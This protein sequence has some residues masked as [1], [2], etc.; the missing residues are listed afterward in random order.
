MRSSHWEKKDGEF[1]LEAAIPANTTATIH[2][3]AAAVADVREGGVPLAEAAGVTVLEQRNGRV[4]VRVGSGTYR[5][6]CPFAS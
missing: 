2:V 5:F 1:V 3:P 4:V 6:A